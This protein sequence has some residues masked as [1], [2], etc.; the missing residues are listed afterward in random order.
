MTTKKIILPLALIF[1]ASC[2]FASGKNLSNELNATAYSESAKTVQA[3]GSIGDTTVLLQQL[4]V[5]NNL[6]AE[7][8][9]SNEELRLQAIQLEH[10]NALLKQITMILKD[11]E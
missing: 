2:S 3:L 5:L 8:L 10:S 11:Q 1:G 7:Q 9:K 4:K 6:Y